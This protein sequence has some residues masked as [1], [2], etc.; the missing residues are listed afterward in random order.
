MHNETGCRFPHYRPGIS[1]DIIDAMMTSAQIPYVFRWYPKNQSDA[2]FT[3]DVIG[4]GMVFAGELMPLLLGCPE[5]LEPP[6][7]KIHRSCVVYC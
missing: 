4:R 6:L 3:H 2:E 1:F 7:L 5:S